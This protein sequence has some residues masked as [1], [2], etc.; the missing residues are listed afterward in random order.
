MKIE[1][2]MVEVAK[3]IYAGC[4]AQGVWEPREV[5][6]EFYLNGKLEICQEDEMRTSTIKVKF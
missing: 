4:K 3:Q 5:E 1:D 2:F 6:L